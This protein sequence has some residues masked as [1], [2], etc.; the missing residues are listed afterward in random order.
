MNDRLSVLQR[1]YR[2]NKR[3]NIFVQ[4]FRFSGNANTKISKRG[5][6]YMQKVLVAEIGGETK[7]V[8]AFGDFDT[9]NLRLL[10][11]GLSPTTVLVEIVLWHP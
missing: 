11:Q 10:G 1:L 6:I 4:T 7:V 3:E 2:S 9:K 8:N 5:S